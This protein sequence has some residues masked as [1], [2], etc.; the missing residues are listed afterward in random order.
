MFDEGATAS[1]DEGF[2]ATDSVEADS[3]TADSALNFAD[4]AVGFP[5]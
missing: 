4:T 2:D 3:D 5:Q 1:D